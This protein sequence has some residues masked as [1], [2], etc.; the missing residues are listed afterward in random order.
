MAALASF[1]FCFQ[2]N[3]HFTPSQPS[4]SPLCLA[5]TFLSEYIEWN[6]EIQVNFL[7]TDNDL[8]PVSLKG[9]WGMI[10]IPPVSRRQ[11]SPAQP[12]LIKSL[13][14]KTLS[15]ASALDANHGRRPGHLISDG[16]GT[17]PKSSQEIRQWRRNFIFNSTGLAAPDA[18]KFCRRPRSS[19]ASFPFTFLP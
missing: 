3:T 6:N 12:G 15:T 11:P 4:V 16:I 1:K 7:I 17:S 18:S 2:K 19:A 10:R 8:L 14:V 5:C 13:T 9:A